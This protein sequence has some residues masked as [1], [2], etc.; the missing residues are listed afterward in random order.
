VSADRL[1]AFA[2]RLTELQFTLQHERS[3]DLRDVEITA[4]EPLLRGLLFTD[5]T[6]TRSLEAQ[7]LSPVT[8]RPLEQLTVAAPTA[9]ARFLEVEPDAECIRRRVAMQIGDAPVGVWAESFLLIDRLPR[10]FVERM[11]AST[12][13]IGGSL[14]QLKLESWRELLCF[15]LGEPPAWADAE[16]PSPVALTRLY[17]ICTVGMPALLISETFAVELERGRYRLLGASDQDSPI[18]SSS[19][20]AD[21]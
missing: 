13:G 10:Q 16:P 11:D 9:A 20:S 14:Q 19:T 7:T 18:S 17:R 4:L 12:T 5:G 1:A 8:V 3:A 2:G 15:G 6:V 21:G